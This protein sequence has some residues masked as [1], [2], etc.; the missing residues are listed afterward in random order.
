MPTPGPYTLDEGTIRDPNGWAL[1]SV[2]FTLGGPIDHEN[3]RLLAASWDL[4]RAAVCSLLWL[5]NLARAVGEDTLVDALPN[6]CGGRVWLR[7][8]IRKATGEET[9]ALAAGTDLAAAASLLLRTVHDTLRHADLTKAQAE[10]LEAAAAQ[11]RAALRG[12]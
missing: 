6:N 1:A 5:D 3:G 4:Y 10:N 9:P 11:V 8:A 2:P 7:E 12:A